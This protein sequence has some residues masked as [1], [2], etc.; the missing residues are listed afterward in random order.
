MAAH[1]RVIW[2]NRAI[3][4]QQRMDTC[5]A[6]PQSPAAPLVL[7]GGGSS[8]RSVAFLRVFTH[9]AG[10]PG[11]RIA[12]ITSGSR[13]PHETGLRYERLFVGLGVEPQV[14]HLLPRA[15]A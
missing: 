1:R 4:Y 15:E 3:A 2:Y 13:E 10:G 7:I 14:C 11:R 8:R 12:V 5:M 6:L 9:L